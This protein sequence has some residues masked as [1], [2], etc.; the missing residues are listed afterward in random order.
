MKD[1]ASRV[2]SVCTSGMISKA[3][4]VSFSTRNKGENEQE[5]KRRL[6]KK[7]GKTLETLDGNHHHNKRLKSLCPSS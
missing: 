2:Q 3:S 1:L 5:D 6:K 4:K 7:R